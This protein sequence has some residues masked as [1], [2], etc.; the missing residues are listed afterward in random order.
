MD[1]LYS[2]LLKPFDWMLSLFGSFHPLLVLVLASL[3]AGVVLLLVFARFSDQEALRTAKDRVRAH[4]LELRL[5]GHDPHLVWAAEK[6]I[7]RANLLYLRLILKP[8]VI[9]LPIFAWML[10]GLY[11]WFEF[12]PLALGE[13]VV[14]SAFI[15]R[16]ALASVRMTAPD[17]TTDEGLQVE[18]PVLRIDQEH[19]CDWRI[20]ALQAG[21][22]RLV[23]STGTQRVER[24]VAVGVVRRSRVSRSARPRPLG[25]TAGGG[26]PLP[27]ARAIERVEVDYPRAR[28]TVLGFEVG[29]VTVFVVLSVAFSFLLKRPFGVT[30]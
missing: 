30:L 7:V 22:H 17:L 15:A 29:W 21:E 6:N 8:L 25:V 18:T 28:L 1:W 20:R 2:A 16:P 14:V 12:R 23:L 19:R 11:G 13:A 5:F 27:D 3:F 24:T 10:L 9:T 4:L 26:D